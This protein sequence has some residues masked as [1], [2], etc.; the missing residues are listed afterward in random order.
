M[1]VGGERFQQ[2]LLKHRSSGSIKFYSRVAKTK[3]KKHVAFFRNLNL[4]RPDCPTKVQ[5]EE[6]FTA[7]G[8][9]SASS[10]L[11]NGTMVFTTSSGS[12]SLKVFNGACEILRKTCGLKEPGFIRTVDYL[13]QIIT[14]NPFAE[15]E[16]NSVH[17]CCASLVHTTDSLPAAQLPLESKRRDVKVLQLTDSEVFSVSIKVGNT[18]GSPNAFLEKLLGIPVTTRSWNTIVRLIR[19]HT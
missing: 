12:E 5:F 8:A 17:A 3:M 2:A 19:K 1:F 14:L 10:F 18:L 7:A 16:P 13:T 15:I 6:A 4:G 11:T 9:V